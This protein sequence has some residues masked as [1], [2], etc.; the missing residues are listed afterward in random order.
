VHTNPRTS[1]SVASASL[2]CIAASQARKDVT[3]LPPDLSQNFDFWRLTAEDCHADNNASQMKSFAFWSKISGP[4]SNNKAQDS[5]FL[6]IYLNAT[7]VKFVQ[8]NNI[9][10]GSIPGGG[11]EFFSSPPGPDLLWV[12]PNLLSN[13]Y[14]GLFPWGLSGLDVKLTTHL[15]LEPR[16]KNAWSYT[17][18]PQYAFMA[19]CSV[20][21]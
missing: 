2:N 13:G 14:Q 12:P 5:S 19:W 8:Q 15:H 1:F 16:S 18:T 10:W 4:D 3:S 7:G 9:F 11:W 6:Q 20:K 21:K 17:S